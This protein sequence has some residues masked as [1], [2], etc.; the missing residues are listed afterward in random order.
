MAIALKAG[1][2][3]AW[4]NLWRNYR[5][6]LIMLL[7]IAVGAWA[8]IFLTAL[9]RGMVDD[10]VRQGIKTLP[11]HVQVHAAAYRDDPSVTHSLPAPNPVQLNVL[12][13]EQVKAWTS[14][15]KVPAMISSE[16]DNRGISLLGVSPKGEIALGFDTTNIVK[17]RFLDNA[18]DSGIV[19]GRKLSQRL[20]TDLGKRVVIMSQ[21]P[22]NDIAERG[23][24]IVGV[25]KAELESLEEN[26]VYAGL[27]VIQEL[28][29]VGTDVSEIAISGLDYRSPNELKSSIRSAVP[30]DW[31]VLSWI[32]LDPYLATMMRVM[33][34][35]VLVWMIVIFLALSFGLVNTL[36]MAVF[37]RV[38]EIGLMRA[39][40]MRPSAIVFQILIESVMLLILGLLLGNL[41]AI[42]TIMPLRGGIDISIV[43]EGMEMMGASS[44]LYPLLLWPDLVLANIVVISLGIVASLLP[45]WHASQYRPVE[46]LTRI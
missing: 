15:I 37:E 12:N 26:V 32:E 16:Y 44:V 22:A 43:S 29:G 9:L 38:R 25:Y 3:M 13:G 17:G 34:G 42:S 21:N 35:F 46:A 41:M 39:L 20:D 6:T 5:R 19:I 7:A 31:E 2:V 24:K 23:F 8:M 36:M 10:M 18:D 28:L 1:S 4:R 33:N 30:D 40:G 27:G 45:A 11:G 14:R